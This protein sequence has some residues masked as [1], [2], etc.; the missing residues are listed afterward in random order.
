MHLSK[1]KKGEKS[2]I[3]KHPFHGEMSSICFFAMQKGEKYI[4]FHQNAIEPLFKII[5]LH[6]LYPMLADLGNWR[7]I[8]KIR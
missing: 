3:F 2:V 8:G 7:G 6:D 5:P 4:E 1:T